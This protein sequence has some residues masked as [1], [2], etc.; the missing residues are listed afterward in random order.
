MTNEEANVWNLDDPDEDKIIHEDL[1]D[2]FPETYKTEDGNVLNIGFR[3]KPRFGRDASF[4]QDIINLIKKY[5]GT[6]YEV[7]VRHMVDSLILFN[8]N[9]NQVED[10]NSGS[11]FGKTDVWEAIQL[12]RCS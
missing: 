1:K 12:Q 8:H 11:K 4:D 2:L 3:R 5:K 9:R 10:V 6:I 7:Y